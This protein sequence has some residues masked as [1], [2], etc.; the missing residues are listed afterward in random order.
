MARAPPARSY[1]R[2]NPRVDRA[3]VLTPYRSASDSYACAAA[4]DIHGYMTALPTRTRFS[5]PRRIYFGDKKRT[6]RYD[7]SSGATVLALYPLHSA[8]RAAQVHEVG[9]D[10]NFHDVCVSPVSG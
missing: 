9:G 6:N 7:M 3:T 10:L 8:F 1:S 2:M 4:Y 5:F